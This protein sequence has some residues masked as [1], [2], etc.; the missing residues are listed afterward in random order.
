MDTIGKDLMI[1]ALWLVL[2]LA[3]VIRVFKLKEE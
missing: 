1:I 3:I 2:L